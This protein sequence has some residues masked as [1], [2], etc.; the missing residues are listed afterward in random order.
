MQE[1][2]GFVW[3]WEKKSR[4]TSE[5][6]RRDAHM[7]TQHLCNT[8]S[9]F[10][11]VHI[12][13]A[14]PC[15]ISPFLF[16]FFSSRTAH[17]RPFSKSDVSTQSKSVVTRPFIY[18]LFAGQDQHLPRWGPKPAVEPLLPSCPTTKP[19]WP[20]CIAAPVPVCLE[21]NP[22]MIQ[23]PTPLPAHKTHIWKISGCCFRLSF[24]HPADRSFSIGTTTSLWILDFL[25]ETSPRLNAGSAPR[26]ETGS[27]STTR[28]DL[29]LHQQQ[30]CYHG[31]PKITD[32]R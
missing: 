32:H 2:P 17:P 22:Q 20:P 21:L 1:T 31:G 10:K 29:S 24:H 9:Y 14:D 3:A 11:S 23:P 30:C 6:T 12:S 19:S 28:Q 7:F 27:S 13:T 25:T 4:A 5:L 18:S 15:K 26:P 16:L 8:L